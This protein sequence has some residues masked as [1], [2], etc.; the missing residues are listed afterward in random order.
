MVSNCKFR[1]PNFLH[2]CL[3]QNPSCPLQH[4]A[5]FESLSC[6]SKVAN[7]KPTEQTHSSY[8]DHD[9]E[10]SISFIVSPYLLTRV[11]YECKFTS[12]RY[13]RCNV[14]RISSHPWYGGMR[15][16]RRSLP[17]VKNVKEERRRNI[18][19]FVLRPVRLITL[20]YERESSVWT[21]ISID[22]MRKRDS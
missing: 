16:L 17:R 13:R 10:R 3:R 18:V 14:N 15:Q 6:D 2:V 20:K 12:L 7:R 8:M 9:K 21:C 11:A 22:A 19:A 4:E 5:V 1:T